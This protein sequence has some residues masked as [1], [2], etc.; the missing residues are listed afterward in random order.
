MVS[1]KSVDLICGLCDVVGRIVVSS[2][3]GNRYVWMKGSQEAVAKDRLHKRDYSN[4]EE[5]LGND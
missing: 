1:D 5:V 2:K 3:D 4:F